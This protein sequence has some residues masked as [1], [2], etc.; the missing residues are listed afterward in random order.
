VNHHSLSNNSKTAP[1]DVN[2]F[3]ED[4]T[5]SGEEVHVVGYR[6]LATT[7]SRI[8]EVRRNNGLHSAAMIRERV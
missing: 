7:I 8:G 4:A 6:I 5:R 3:I 1:N 2:A